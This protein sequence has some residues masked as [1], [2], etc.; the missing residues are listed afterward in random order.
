MDDIVERLR[1]QL[2]EQ[3]HHNVYGDVV[4]ERIR[5]H[6]KH[7][8]GGQSM[9]HANW[10]DLLEWTTVLG[11]EVGEVDKAIN[12]HRHGNLTDAEFKDELRKEVIQTAAMCLAWVEAIDG[13]DE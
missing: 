9:E 6:E 11:E 2:F 13:A 7:M 10:D 4:H 1:K 8:A 12:E 3:T 5:A